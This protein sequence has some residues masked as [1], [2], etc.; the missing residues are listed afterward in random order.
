M[1]PTLEG[2]AHHAHLESAGTRLLTVVD[3]V[4]DDQLDAPTPCEG[5]TVGQLL[6][7]LTGMCLAFTAAA[8]KEATPQ[9]D[10]DPSAGDWPPAQP[11]WRETLHERVPALVEAWREASAWEGTTK[12][13]GMELP[14]E[15]AGVVALE[16]MVVHGW[17]LARATGQAYE[18]NDATA[19]AV[20]GF[21][22][23]NDPDGTPGLFGPAVPLEDEDA[24]L[25]AKV[26]ARTGRDPYW[27]AH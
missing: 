19:A 17:D 10:T 25:F 8:R 26:V 13:G 11:G 12:A 27:T 6:Q 14:G 20:Q 18:V 24:P 1:V 4:R 5:L 15:V 22:S 16:E 7:H 23:T 3:G 21:V 9:A 2:M